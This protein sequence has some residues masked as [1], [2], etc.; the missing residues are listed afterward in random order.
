MD[1]V[2]W[3]PPPDCDAGRTWLNA[4]LALLRC[5]PSLARSIV[6][7]A[8]AVTVSAEDGQRW[9]ARRSDGAV[10]PPGSW[11]QASGMAL[12]EARAALALGSEEGA[13]MAERGAA[14]HSGND[15]MAGAWANTMLWRTVFAPQTAHGQRVAAL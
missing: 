6:Q 4:V 1:A 11:R 10:T 7:R 13:S 14:A 8:D 2:V 9:A 3:R 15:P 5:R 12:A